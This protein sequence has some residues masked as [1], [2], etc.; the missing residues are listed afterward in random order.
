MTVAWPEGV[1]TDHLEG[2]HSIDAF[3]TDPLATEFEAGN[4]RRRQRGTV[5]VETRSE[6]LVM[7]NAQFA[8]FKAWRTGTLKRETDRFTKSM[9]E[10][11]GAVVRTCEFVEGSLKA[12]FSGA[13]WRV[14]YTLRVFL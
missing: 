10:A 13:R 7:T 5:V 14:S 6:T 1:P 3:D 4:K 2:A 8:A 11:G 12:A 9:R